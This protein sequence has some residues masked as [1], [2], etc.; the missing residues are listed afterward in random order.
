[1]WTSCPH[2]GLDRQ[3]PPGESGVPSLEGDWQGYHFF[4]PDPRKRRAPHEV[5][6]VAA[7]FSNARGLPRAGGG[8]YHCPREALP[9]ICCSS[10]SFFLPLVQYHANVGDGSSFTEESYMSASL[11][12]LL[13]FYIFSTGRRIFAMTETKKVVA[14]KG[15]TVLAAHC[16]ACIAHDR[17][18]LE[19]EARWSTDKDAPQYATE[20]KQ[21]DILVDVALGALR[22]SIDAEVRDAAPGDA[23]GAEAALLAQELFPNGLTAVTQ[24]TFPEELAQLQR[25][26][27]RL[28][29]ARWSTVVQELG[30]AR[31]LTRLVQL[32]SRYAAAIAA[33]VAAVTFADVRNIRATGQTLMLQAVAMILGLHPSESAAD[34]A[35]REELLAPI[36]RQNEAIRV[37]LRNRRS[38]EDVNPDTGEVIPASGA[39]PVAPDP[40]TSHPG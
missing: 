22:D 7:G 38:V 6:D 37:Y 2:L 21:V 18:A 13:S 10:S 8:A 36:L 40:T 11:T 9:Q 15:H 32:E 31:R 25:I 34:I 28:Q 30:L 16:D 5:D 12:A 4:V 39:T 35:A 1:M 3:G 26:I 24:A 14:E 33:P 27:A 29:S 17:D 19:V 20:A 23:L